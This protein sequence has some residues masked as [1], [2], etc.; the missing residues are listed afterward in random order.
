MNSSAIATS[1]REMGV[2]LAYALWLTVATFI[3][4]AIVGLFR[5][6]IKVRPR[7]TPPPLPRQRYTDL[8]ERVLRSFSAGLLAP[9]EISRRLGIA[10]EAVREAI[11]NL[12]ARNPPLV[13]RTLVAPSRF[14]WR[15]TSLG[16][17]E[18]N[19]LFGVSIPIG[20]EAIPTITARVLPLAA[21]PP[22]RRFGHVEDV[23]VNQDTGLEPAYRVVG[24]DGA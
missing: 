9:E 21:R 14:G 6:G 4:L 11:T 8:Q 22:S 24:K 12:L 16:W 10:V 2:H 13:E 19:R 23:A 17:C 5:S 18:A 20:V 7:S 15:L 3:T 1:F